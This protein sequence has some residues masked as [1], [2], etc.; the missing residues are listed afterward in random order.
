MRGLAALAVVVFHADTFYGARDQP[1][2]RLLAH[3]DVGVAVFFFLTGF[4][5]YRP[6]VTAS[7]GTAPRMP[8]R[9]YWWRRFLR[10]APAYWI[11]LA[12]LAAYPTLTF[13][14]HAGFLPNVLFLQ[15]YKESWARSGIPPA[16]SI[17][18]EVSFYLALPIYA[19][20]IHRAALRRPDRRG[21]IELGTL[22]MLMVLSL[23]YRELLRR[24][25]APRYAPDPLPGTL[26]WFIPGMA[27]AVIS[28]EA[29]RTGGRIKQL[30]AAKPWACW[31]AAL[32]VYA[33]LLPSNKG[34]DDTGPGM[35]VAYGVIAALL[36]APL[37]FSE[38]GLPIR[39]VDRPWLR[40]LGVISYGIYIYHWPLLRDMHTRLAGRVHLST[41]AGVLVLALAGMVVAIAAGAVSYYL[42]ERPV[43]TLKDAARLKRI[44]LLAR[45]LGVADLAG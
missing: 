14:Q 45:W 41:T 37:V 4:L 2:G 34:F 3:L 31:T 40:W 36:V 13:A 8:I 30:V 29:G 21:V 10:I 35:F 12:A 6:F 25:G 23:S 5:L 22:A 24:I 33:A 16:W 27:A 17:C 42:I 18:V 1:V 9:L 26:A 15:T 28:V 7:R 38:D 44:P 39:T 32:I 19:A 43:L 11:A 20:L